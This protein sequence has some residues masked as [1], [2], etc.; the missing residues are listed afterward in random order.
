MFVFHNSDVSRC[1]DFPI[2][3][4]NWCTCFK[5]AT[6]ILN[7]IIQLLSQCENF[8]W[9]RIWRSFSLHKTFQLSY[10]E[11]WKDLKQSELLSAGCS[12]HLENMKLA[13]LQPGRHDKLCWRREAISSAAST[14]RAERAVWRRLINTNAFVLMRTRVLVGYCCLALVV[15]KPGT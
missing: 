12:S 1:Q 14:V 9:R 5:K 4:C 15:L 7:F 6:E 8:R 11:P 13:A 2:H 3:L 10:K